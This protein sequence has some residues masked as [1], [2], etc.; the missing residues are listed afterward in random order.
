MINT[1]LILLVAIGAALLLLE[2]VKYVRRRN[3][4]AEENVRPVVNGTCTCA[5]NEHCCVKNKQLRIAC[6][7]L[8]NGLSSSFPEYKVLKNTDRLIVVGKES[9]DSAEGFV[10]TVVDSI[11]EISYTSKQGAKKKWHF[12]KSASG[13]E[14]LVS[15]RDSLRNVGRTRAGSVIGRTQSV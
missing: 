2:L 7:S 3:G 14:I 13:P 1:I 6:S 9:G 4:R 15:V 10:I 8:V 5:D 12:P 11:L